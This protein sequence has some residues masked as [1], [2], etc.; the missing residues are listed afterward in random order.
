MA[1][2]LQNLLP[3]KLLY[4]LEEYKEV[5]NSSDGMIYQGFKKTFNK[6]SNT[7]AESW[8]S[9]TDQRA[10]A[11]K[12]KTDEINILNTAKYVDERTTKD[13]MRNRESTQ[14]RF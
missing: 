5:L 13:E 4:T 2:S 11:S 6:Y 14:S 1:S 7:R 9:N 10:A 12:S 8:Q 3:S